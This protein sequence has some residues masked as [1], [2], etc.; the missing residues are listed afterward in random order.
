MHYFIKRE[1][2]YM[3]AEQIFHTGNSFLK[4]GIIALKGAEDLAHKIDKFLVNWAAMGPEARDTFIIG[5]ECP[6]FSSGDGKA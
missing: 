5:A 6:R 4:L 1:L 3:D 2:M